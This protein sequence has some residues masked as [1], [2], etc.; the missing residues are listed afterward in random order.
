MPPTWSPRFHTAGKLTETS[1]IASKSFEINEYSS[2]R[3][4]QSLQCL[5]TSVALM[6]FRWLLA[7]HAEFGRKKKIYGGTKASSYSQLV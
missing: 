4:L 1:F 5:F 7:N 3:N 2:H 6:N